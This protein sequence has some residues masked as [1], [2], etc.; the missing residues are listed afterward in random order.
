MLTFSSKFAS[1]K[2]SESVL[3]YLDLE[4]DGRPPGTR[5]ARRPSSRSPLK[6]TARAPG[7]AQ[8]RR[9][10]VDGLHRDHRDGSLHPAVTTGT[11]PGHHCAAA[12]FKLLLALGTVGSGDAWKG[13]WAFL[14]T[15]G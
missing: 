4:V 1:L 14:R 7:H 5:V 6:A 3:P 15:P 13:P 12:G 11:G 10:C 2:L 9:G 8:T